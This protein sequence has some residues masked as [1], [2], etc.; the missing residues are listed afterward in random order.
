MNTHR[1]AVGPV[2]EPLTAAEP[3]PAWPGEGGGG[4][5]AR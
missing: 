3:A 5:T 2:V 4:V 1:S